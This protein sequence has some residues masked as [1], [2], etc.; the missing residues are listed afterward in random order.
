MY[1]NKMSFTK[2]FE[3]VKKRRN[4]IDPNHGF[5]QQLKNFEKILFKK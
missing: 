4:I 3:Y 5:I 2:A 1:K